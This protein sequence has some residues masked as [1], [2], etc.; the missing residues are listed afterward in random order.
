[1]TLCTY[2]VRL[3]ANAVTVSAAYY[4]GRAII[5]MWSRHQLIGAARDLEELAKNV[6][7]DMAP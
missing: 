5:E 2:V 3:A 4:F 7:V 1:M 6:P